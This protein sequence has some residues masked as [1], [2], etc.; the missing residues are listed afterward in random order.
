MCG[1]IALAIPHS[2]PGW[3]AVGG[4]VLY[5][6]GRILTYLLLG[7]IIGAFGRGLFLAGIQSWFSVLI[8][9]GLIIVAL[10]SLNVELYIKQFPSIRLLQ[11]WVSRNMGKLLQRESWETPFLIGVLNGLLPCGL[12]YVAI[13]GAVLS[14]SWW[15]SALYMGGF[16]AGTLPLM[17]GTALLGQFINLNWRQRL[18][19]LSPVLLGLFGLY[20]MARGINFHLPETLRFWEIG[21]EVPMCH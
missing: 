8:G 10:F 1:P 5:N 15:Q 2:R 13:A 19:Q 9:A 6:L 7:L 20:F 16:G 14:D 21:Q 18:R 17:L 11:N 4:A 3:R 12:V